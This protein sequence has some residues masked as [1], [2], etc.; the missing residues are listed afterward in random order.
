[1]DDYWYD[2]QMAFNREETTRQVEN[3][4]EIRVEPVKEQTSHDERIEAIEQDTESL[5]VPLQVD[6]TLNQE[7]DLRREI[8]DHMSVEAIEAIYEQQAN[9]MREQLNI[10]S[11]EIGIDAPVEIIG[12]PNTAQVEQIISTSNRK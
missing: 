3:M 6:I 12:R 4:S 8:S 5:R 10:A 7:N 11:A 9:A 1:M 2:R